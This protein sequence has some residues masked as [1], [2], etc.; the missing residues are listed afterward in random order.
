MKVY[1]SCLQF[2][3]LSD[4][5]QR[6]YLGDILKKPVGI[7]CPEVEIITTKP[8]LIVAIIIDAKPYSSEW[9]EALSSEQRDSLQEL[10]AVLTLMIELGVW[11]LFSLDDSNRENASRYIKSWGACRNLAGLLLKQLGWS[12][13]WPELP[14]DFVL[15]EY[16]YI[17]EGDHFSE[18]LR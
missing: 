8:L 11:D 18:F 7:N 1:K 3:A 15:K 2:L 17:V 6:E 9:F 12:Q 5:R 13:S 4:R 10:E 16:T 14:F